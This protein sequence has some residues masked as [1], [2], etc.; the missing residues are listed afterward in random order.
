LKEFLSLVSKPVR[1]L[2][3]EIHSIK[4][5]PAEVKLKFCLAFPDVYEVGMSHLGIQILYHILNTRK[6]V[7]CERAFAPWVDME[8]VLREKRI[9]LSSLESSLPLN[10]FDILG[11]SLQYELCFTNL[12]NMLDLSDIPLLSKD[13]DDRFPII[14]AGGPLTFNP[15]PVA[16]FF[17]AMVI[18]DGEEVVSEICD[19][20]LQWKEAKARKEEFLKSLSQLRGIYVPSLHTEGQRIHK[21]IVSDLNQTFFPTCP[22]VPY[23]KVVHDR[24]NIEIARGCKRACRFCEAGF[25]HRPYRERSPKTVLETL[26]TSL[27]RTGYEEL[28]LLSLS[29]GDYSSIGPLLSGLM[30]RYES[31]KV[32]VSFPSLRIESVVGRLAAEVKRVRKTGFTI[33]PEAGTERLR[34]VINKELDERVFFQGLSDLF[35][36]GWKNVKLYF[37]MGLPTEK[38]EDLKGIFELTKQIGSLGEKQKTHPHISVSV[39]TFVPKPHTP[40]QWESQ[41]S[42]EEMKEKLHFIK[43]GVQ[44][45]HLHFK[46]QDPHLSFLEGI[47]SVG[48]RNLS[49]VLVEAFRLGCRFD[50][51]SDQFQYPLWKE[52]FEKI[53]RKMDWHTRKRRF[54]DV[55][56]WSFI[57]TG[58]DAQFLWEE[59][60]RGLEEKVSPPC[61]KENCR[62][63]GICDGKAIV[64]R[65]GDLEEVKALERTAKEDIRKKGMKKKIRLKF[66]KV[67]E[68]RFLSHLELAHL[69]YRAS[70][71]ADLPL[72]FS[73]GFHPMPRI[74]FA[75]ALPVGMESL[76]EV[77]DMECEGRITPA[78]VMKKLNRTLPPGIEI[79]EAEEVPLFFHLSSLPHP[80]AYWI[81]L[82]PLL[83]KEEVSLKIK[84]ALDKREFLVN[85][86]RD[87]KKRSVDIRPLIEKMEIKGKE[88]RLGEE[89]Q[90]GME[91]VLRRAMGRTAKPIE[92]V[93]AV[94]G[95][96]WEP[97]TQLKVT[98]LE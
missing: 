59:Y 32:A 48:D 11:F 15:A 18:G 90:W 36:K 74:I 58:M 80:S 19:L 66:R 76:T 91:L 47:F 20:A 46:W 5:D 82:E 73:E 62:R 13:R 8:R 49:Q 50:G 64:V 94:L 9:P 75:T 31:E 41:V 71:R 7:G 63:C 26:K 45:N 61:V 55:L 70:K 44:R 35:S 96:D 69:F 25:I 16:D 85:Q 1:Y 57:E 14:L 98:K 56:P 34:R 51:W 72:C 43:D 54:E 27:E 10:Q 79:T 52:A 30:D 77:L 68:L 97:L 37:M 29:A 21:R 24:L 88:E 81:P 87:G 12:L 83:S 28:S 89:P 78:E 42:L 65:E 2:G 33:A 53:G 17:D 84:K 60:R 4:K 40:F 38:E 67:G 23:M 22:I 86:E 93:G 39:S 92:I 6:G 3:Q 95:L